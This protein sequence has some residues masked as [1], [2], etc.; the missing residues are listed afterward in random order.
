MRKLGLSI[1][2]KYADLDSILEYLEMAHSYGFSRIFTC[3][4]SAHD[5]DELNQLISINKQAKSMNYEIFADVNPS[6]FTQLG[7]SYHDLSFFKNKMYLD[8]IR[9]DIGFSGVEETEMTFAPSDL[10]IELNISSGTKYIENILSYQPNREKLV[11][12]H[13]FYP[14][15]YTGLSRKQFLESTALFKQHHLRTAAMISSQHGKYGPWPVVDGGL[16]TLEEHRN[17]P[18]DS[19]AKDLWQTQLIDDLIIGNMF[20]SESEL[21]TLGSLDRYQLELS[22]E[23]F[24]D[25]TPVERAIVLNESHINRG[26]VSDYVIRSTVSREQYR[27]YDIQPHRTSQIMPGDITIDNNDYGRYKGE[28]QIALKEMENTGNTN[29][30]GKV[31]PQEHNL[32]KRIRPWEHFML[33]EKTF[34]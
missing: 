12:C 33:K 1:Y 6:V 4:I 14:R 28:L 34:E 25:T 2:P 32:L 3:L 24:E 29:V 23:L 19:Q 30:I 13:N 9:L 10:K 20:A 17:Q 26:D 18:I 31:I 7:L 5:T 21:K 11:G 27:K 22:V 15:R 16:P 8:G